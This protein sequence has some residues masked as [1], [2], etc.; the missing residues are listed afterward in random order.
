[1]CCLTFI[2]AISSII[3]FDAF[4]CLQYLQKSLKQNA[5]K[6]EILL[7]RLNPGSLLEIQF[8]FHEIKVHSHEI[9]VHS[10]KSRFTL[11]K[12]RFTLRGIFTSGPSQT[13]NSMSANPTKWLNTLKQFVGKLPMNC[14][15]VFDQFVKL[16]LKGLIYT[17]LHSRCLTEFSMYI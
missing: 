12:S 14:L 6:N 13:F 2:V 1:M 4:L 8:H 5:H 11:M 17:M 16:A 15:R 9:K 7:A 3:Y 10:Q